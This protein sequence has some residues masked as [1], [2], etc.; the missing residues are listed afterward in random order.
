MVRDGMIYI[1]TLPVKL[2]TKEPFMMSLLVVQ[3]NML[4][5]QVTA[6]GFI[7]PGMSIGEYYLLYNTHFNPTSR[8]GY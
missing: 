3:I 6:M 2:G 1:P 4:S 7:C 8:L 5:S